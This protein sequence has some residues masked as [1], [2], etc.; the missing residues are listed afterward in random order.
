MDQLRTALIG[1]KGVG[2]QHLK[3][4][5]A[6]PRAALVAVADLDRAAAVELAGPEVP[7]FADYQ[8]MLDQA[9]PD[10]VIVAT[11]HFLHAPMTLAALEANAHV[12]VEKPIA[13]RVSEADRM[14]E[15]AQR[16]GRVLAVGH[17]YRA[18]AA[19]RRLKEIVDG[20][21]LGRIYRVLWQWLENRPES[22]Y[23]RDI[24]RCTWRHAGGGVLMNQTS[25]DIDL[26]CWLLGKPVEVTAAVDNLAHRHEVED[27]ALA[28]VRFASGALASLQFIGACRYHRLGRIGRPRRWFRR[29]VVGG[30]IAIG[31]LL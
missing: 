24:W 20:G 11:P 12:L 6:N 14:V 25:H 29:G 22:Y 19:N 18:F 16:R 28:T 15:E 8:T 2:R 27:T 10:A 13:M 31:R 23:G 26:L 9:R 30:L 17:N 3:G 5:Q 21:R 4:L 1:V 7:Y